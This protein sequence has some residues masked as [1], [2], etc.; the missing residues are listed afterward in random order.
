MKILVL[1]VGNRMPHWV[2]DGFAQYAGR[3]PRTA[4]MS[5]VEVKPE[6]RSSGKTPEQMMAAEAQRIEA[7]LPAGCERIVL[8]ERGRE[9]GSVELSAWL[10]GRMAAGRDLAFIIGGP[11]GLD[12]ALRGSAAL[13]L[14][15]SAFTLPHGLARVMLAEQLYRA[16]TIL[17][18]HPYH[19]E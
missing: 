17:Q 7:A 16:T 15:L 3:M 11:D 10:E 19:R 14:R 2:D 4:R 1:A 18:N 8:D 6:P 12:A 13:S 5:L 9:F